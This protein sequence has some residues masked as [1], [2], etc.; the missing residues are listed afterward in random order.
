MTT[1]SAAPEP[2]N[3]LR[4]CVAHAGHGAHR[5]VGHDLFR[6]LL[7]EESLTGLIALS[8]AGRRIS[9][10]ER[11]LLDCLSVV[12][13]VADPRIWPLKINRLVA[14]YGGTLAAFGAQVCVE[15][16]LIGMWSAGYAAQTLMELHTALSGSPEADLEALLEAKNRLTGYGVPFRVRDE[17]LDALRACLEER[18]R[19]NMPFWQL[20][21][22]MSDIVVRTR[23]IAPNIVIGA[24]AM[25]LDMGFEVAHVSAMAHFFNL[26]VFVAN[27]YEGAAQAPAIL[28]RLPDAT[29]DYVG[30][31]P[32]L[33]ERAQ[34]RGD[35]L[36]VP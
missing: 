23:G 33:S 14:A 35:A 12:L 36:S 18:G 21:E 19:T 28:R 24:A 34:R 16:D 10:E 4:T 2:A 22:R 13:S 11:E 3:V 25:L 6:G 27:A 9:P 1:A 5:F 8:I 7:G 17:R 15:G 30:P 31:P 26:P 20:Q 29:I 32:R